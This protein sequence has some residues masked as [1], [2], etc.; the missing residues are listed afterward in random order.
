MSIQ[1]ILL[2][3]DGSEMAKR[4][5]AVAAELAGQLGAKVNVVHV[6]ELP[7]PV[8]LEVPVAASPELEAEFREAGKAILAEG[9][10]LS[11][12]SS[13]VE[14]TLLSGAPGAAI[15]AHA[16][17]I[18]CDLIVLGHRGL[19]GFE[20]FFLGSISE[21]VLRHAQCPVLVVKE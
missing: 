16:E 14:G 13:L 9:R 1:S 15:V 10:R 17:R 21:Y 8:V 7:R 5:A 4:A 20:R 11:G 12:E 19:T 6:Q 18:G 2:A 3:Y